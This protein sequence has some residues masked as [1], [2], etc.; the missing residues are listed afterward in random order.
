[1][2]KTDVTR[3]ESCTRV[4]AAARAAVQAARDILEDTEPDTRWS[5]EVWALPSPP[6][7]VRLTLGG[8][9]PYG[10]VPPSFRR[11]WFLAL[12]DAALDEVRL[13]SEAEQL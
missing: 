4:C 9:V 10:R 8:G 3:I 2:A 6:G 7:E 5:V 13:L 12:A 1:M 11:K